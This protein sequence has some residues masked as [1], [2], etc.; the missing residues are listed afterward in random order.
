MAAAK[1][2]TGKARE[3]ESRKLFSNIQ[4]YANFGKRIGDGLHGTFDT[5]VRGVSHN[6][7]SIKE[8]DYNYVVS[9]DGEIRFRFTI[10]A[11]SLG[12]AVDVN[13]L[14]ENSSITLLDPPYPR[15]A[16]WEQKKFPFS[17]EGV[18]RLIG[19]IHLDDDEAVKKL[20]EL[21]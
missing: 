4:D 8:D 15:P 3:K 12:F 11:G 18:K 1:K 21:L 6:N 19:H 14:P 5:I 7:A 13:I 20:K 2:L 16:G 17:E 10:V 9:G